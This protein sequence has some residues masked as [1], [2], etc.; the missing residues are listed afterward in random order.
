VR[1][2]FS[3]D[4]AG[5]GTWFHVPPELDLQDLEPTEEHPNEFVRAGDLVD[6]AITEIEEAMWGEYYAL[7]EAA[8]LADH[9]KEEEPEARSRTV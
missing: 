1:A 4:P 9:T 6:T 5:N 7:L 8:E 2:I 3:L